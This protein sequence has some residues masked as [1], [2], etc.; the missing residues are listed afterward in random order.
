LAIV[1]NVSS[2]INEEVRRR[3][4]REKMSILRDQVG[5]GGGGRR[6]EAG[7]G[8]G[9]RRWTRVGGRREKKGRRLF[10]KTV[11]NESLGNYKTAQVPREARANQSPSLRSQHR[12]KKGSPDMVCKN[13]LKTKISTWSGKTH[14]KT[15]EVCFQSKC[16]FFWFT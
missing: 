3:E 8:V 4:N 7:T 5:L 16:F 13:N 2:H 9:S 6:Q 12:S 11:G 10:L 14:Q 1:G 15:S